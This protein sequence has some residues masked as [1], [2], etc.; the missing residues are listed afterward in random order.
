M[1]AGIHMSGTQPTTVTY[2]FVLP[3]DLD[4]STV[5]EAYFL[6]MYWKRPRFSF[7]AMNPSAFRT[8]RTTS[9]CL[10]SAP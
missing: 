9:G 7:N 10:A 5:S 4:L 1:D 8:D 3:S 6:G 2:N